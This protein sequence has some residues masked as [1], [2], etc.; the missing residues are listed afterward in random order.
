MNIIVC[1][2]KNLGISFNHRRV[3]SDKTIMSDILT[4]TK[5]NTISISEFSKVIFNSYLGN[6]HIS[7][8]IPNSFSDWFFLENDTIESYQN[9]IN[10]LVIY[11]FNRIYPSDIKL[12]IDLSK[13]DL[14]SS[15][16]FPGNSHETITRIIYKRR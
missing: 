7:E 4:L 5:G 10:T 11:N 1:V 6:Y 2:D 15:T 12:K 14:V 9:D 8:E 16:D 3:S 13:F